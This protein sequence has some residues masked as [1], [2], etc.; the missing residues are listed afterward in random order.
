MKSNELTQQ[1][2]AATAG[3]IGFMAAADVKP[4][5]KVLKIDGRLPG[6]AG[7]KLHLTAK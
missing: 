4:G 2:V 3:A 7:Y 1:L 5:V 6:E